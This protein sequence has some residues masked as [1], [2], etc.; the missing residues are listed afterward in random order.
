MSKWKT[1]ASEEVFSAGFFRL[2]RD[3]CQLP[4]GRV[5]PRYYVVE[6]PDWIHIVP[7]TKEKELV[8]VRQYRH[9][10]GEEFLEIPGGSMSPRMSE[11]PLI[12][13]QRELQEETGFTSQKWELIGDHFPNPA[14][15]SNRL[16]TYLALD[17]KKTSALQLD[18]FEDLTVELL[19]IERALKQLA[20]GE[21]KH[22]L[23]ISSLM[24]ARD[25]L[26]GLIS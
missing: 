23:V 18:P 6:F 25:Q 21:F 12:A 14:L 11:S 22:S 20:Q 9:G 19:P 15:Q 8:L 5:M 3:Q 17:C 10:V 1:L 7:V 13:A 2:R 16:Y 26:L 4:D 24:M